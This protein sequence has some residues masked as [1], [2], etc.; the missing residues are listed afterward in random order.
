MPVKLFAIFRRADDDTSLTPYGI[1]LLRV[2]LAILWLIHGL[3]KVIHDG[4]L[5]T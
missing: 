4:M 1:G 2:T 3:Y 5:S